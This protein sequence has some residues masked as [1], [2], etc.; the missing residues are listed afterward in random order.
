VFG[1]LHDDVGV[2]WERR[3]SGEESYLR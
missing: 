2:Y 3:V 1:I